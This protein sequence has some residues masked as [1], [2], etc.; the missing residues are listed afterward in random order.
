MTEE[1]TAE[2]FRT[3]A[4]GMRRQIDFQ[5]ELIEDAKYIIDSMLRGAERGEYLRDMQSW[6][7]KHGRVKVRCK[8]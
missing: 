5:A 2:S 8:T 4:A 7:E 1:A 3:V 6:I